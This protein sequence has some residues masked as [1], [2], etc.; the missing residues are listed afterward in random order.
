MEENAFQLDYEWKKKYTVLDKEETSANFTQVTARKESRRTKER[1]SKPLNTIDCDKL[2]TG[3]QQTIR[4]DKEICPFKMLTG[5]EDKL[6]ERMHGLPT[7][8]KDDVRRRR[9]KYRDRVEYVE[10]LPNSL[11]RSPMKKM[12]SNTVKTQQLGL[13]TMEKKVPAELLPVP[14]QTMS[15][16]PSL[17]DLQASGKKSTLM[18]SPMLRTDFTKLDTMMGSSDVND[19]QSDLLASGSL[20]EPKTA[21]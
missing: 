3:F 8:T 14:T 1:N 11:L 20:F 9:E 7:V 12:H 18:G 17:A 13:Y 21:I 4:N 19:T 16:F 5:R 6:F 15:E 2:I 10:F